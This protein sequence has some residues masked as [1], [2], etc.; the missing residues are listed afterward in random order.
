MAPGSLGN[1][2]LGSLFWRAMQP[3]F[4]AGWPGQV[5]ARTYEYA[6]AV[7]GR[8]IAAMPADARLI[9]VSDHGFR[10]WHHTDGPDAFFAAAGPGLRDMDGPEPERLTRGDLRRIGRIHDVGPTLLAL[11]GLPVGLDMDGGPIESV[12]APD[13]RLRRPAPIATWDDA[14]WLAA[15]GAATATDAPP[16]GHA[17]E[18]RLE[19]LRALGYI[20]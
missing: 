7:L 6:D 9:V 3:A 5:L 11:A 14:A 16:A 18:E 8:L 17:D 2:A 12:L 4:G 13:P 1:A 15:R 19:Q 20:Q 10:P